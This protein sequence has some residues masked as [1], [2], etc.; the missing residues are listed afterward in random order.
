M[1][2]GLVL[3]KKRHLDSEKNII[4]FKVYENQSNNIKKNN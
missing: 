3:T 2:I 1:P 4:Y